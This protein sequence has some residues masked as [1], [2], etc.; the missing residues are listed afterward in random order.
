MSKELEVTKELDNKKDEFIGIASHELKTPLTSIKAYMQLLERSE[1]K[2]QDRRLVNK[3]NSNVNKLNNL[4]GD[5]LDGSKVQSGQLKLNNAPFELKKMIH[6]SVENVQ[7]MYST[8]Q[9]IF[10]TKIPDLVLQGD[11]LRLEQA[12]TNLLVN[13][14]KYSPGADAVYIKTEL[15]PDHVKIEIIDKGIGM[16]KENQERI[17][18]RFYRAQELSPVISGLGMGLYI[19]QEIIK[20]H[21]G[22]IGVES[23][24][25][26]GSTFFIALP[27]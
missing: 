17:F 1:L 6:E 27:V 18:D 4:I 5:L 19:A 20:R 24:P 11:I 2:E 13:A 8:H 12:M 25:G 23:E 10:L 21:K 26:Q 7:H 9:L 16:T 22:N 15:M 3:A 14:I